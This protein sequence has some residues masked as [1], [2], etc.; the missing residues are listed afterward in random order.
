MTCCKVKLFEFE[1][2][3]DIRIFFSCSYYEIWWKPLIEDFILGLIIFEIILILNFFFR[4]WGFRGIWNIFLG[5]VL[6]WGIGGWREN[7][8][9]IHPIGADCCR[10]D[11]KGS[12]SIEEFVGPWSCKGLWG[13]LI[14]FSLEFR[15]WNKRKKAWPTPKF[16]G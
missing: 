10:V 7:R 14:F 2:K 11:V 15:G 4:I 12:K 3:G 1:F 8:T 6:F 13:L 16:C 5:G 9:D